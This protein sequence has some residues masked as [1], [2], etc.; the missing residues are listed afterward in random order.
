[1]GKKRITYTAAFKAK[2]ALAAQL[3]VHIGFRGEHYCVVFTLPLEHIQLSGISE[4]RVLVYRHHEE[5]VVFDYCYVDSGGVDWF[6]PGKSVFGH[7]RS[8]LPVVA[9]PSSL[10]EDASGFFFSPNGTRKYDQSPYPM[11]QTCRRI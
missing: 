10:R 2:T 9:V 8:I 4:R 5:Q 1:M 3:R 6:G 7:R 11:R